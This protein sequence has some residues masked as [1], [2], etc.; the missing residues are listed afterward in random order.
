MRLPKRY[1]AA[2]KESFNMVGLA[3]A[4]SVSAAMLNP[5]PLLAALVA[6]AAYMIFVPDSRWYDARLSRRH[7]AE[8]EQRRRELKEEVLPLLRAAMQERFR[9][10]EETRRQIDAQPMQDQNWFREVLRKLDY[11]IEKFLMFARKDAQFRLYLRSLRD[12]VCGVPA[13]EGLTEESGSSSGR[14]RSRGQGSLPRAPSPLT[15]DEN[16]TGDP[17]DR[18]VQRAVSEVQAKYDEEMNDLRQMMEAEEDTNTKAVLQ[19]RLDVLQRRHEFVSKMGK[20]LTNLNHQLQ[21]LEDTFGLINDEIRARSPEQI[22]ADIE[23]VVWQT[24][25][26]TRVLEEVAPF[27]QVIARA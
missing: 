20:I 1:V 7:D 5:L 8:I 25:T 14:R 19:K 2:F 4:A 12:E 13:I 22:L 3:T 9:R 10:L 23:D 26:M 17:S 18:G 15:N 6:E 11:L 27:E 21:L 16:R 24:D